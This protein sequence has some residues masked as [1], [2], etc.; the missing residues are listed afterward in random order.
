MEKKKHISAIIVVM[1]LMLATISPV[2]AQGQKAATS[3]N[4]DRPVKI[5]LWYG[6]LMSEAGPPPQDWIVYDIVRDK[7]NIELSL[8]ALPSNQ[9]DADVKIQAA[10]AANNLPDI[11]M[12]ARA[13]WLRLV[14]Q[15]LL[16][17]VDSLY[18]KMPTRT[19]V[20]HDANSIA[21]TTYEGK[22]YGMATP[23]S[24]VRNEGLIIRKD[25]L[26]ALGL[27]VP[28]T[29]EEL[30]KVMEA[31]TF[32]DPDR[33]GKNDTWGYGAFLEINTYE[34]GLGRRFDPLF[35]AFGVAGTWNLTEE[36]F[37]LN[38]RKP[39]YYDAMAYVKRMVDAG[40]I[41]PN[42]LSYR[43]D[44]FRAAWKQ[45]KFGI[46]REQNGALAMESNYKPFD[47]NFPNGEWM[48]INP[49][50]GPNGDASVGVYMNTYRIY[51]VSARAEKEGKMD[52]IA[53]LFE[54]MSSDEGYYLLGWGQEGVNYTF[55]K[56]GIPSADGLPNPQYAYTQPQGRP[57][58]QLANLVYMYGD[59]ELKATFPTYTTA[60]GRTM[61]ALDVLRDMQTKAWTDNTG[62]DTM[63]LPN[64]DLKRFY[65]QGVAEF[66]TGRRTLTQQNW[67]AFVS[68]FDRLGGKA[69]EE[70]GYAHARDNNLLQK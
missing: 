30:F 34:E 48:V 10:G 28:R 64:D 1:S 9:G 45:G 40:V 5:D 44:D 58:I 33:N 51:A 46:M 68:D 49:P 6:A 12:V 20:Y 22:S 21:Y 17:P 52:A 23:G 36:G 67:S 42:W 11:F 19:E 61:S 24:I 57:V 43:K 26:D 29:T 35:G 55:N 2:F 8:T 41:D 53:R 59:S 31:F 39:G 65:E 63:P 25:W 69:W 27:D 3:G 16:A 15:G 4:A 7:L 13:P 70:A 47:T 37:G 54:W 14:K 38:V 66:M 62:A 56:E 18:P 50:T 60:N 32:N